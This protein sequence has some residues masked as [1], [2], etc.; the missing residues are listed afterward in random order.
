MGERTSGEEEA[1]LE[2][3]RVPLEEEKVAD[4]DLTANP[5][6]PI[7]GFRI[8][9]NIPLFHKLKMGVMPVM[10]VSVVV[11]LVL[12]V[13]VSCGDTYEYPGVL[14]CGPKI[15]A[16][17]VGASFRDARTSAFSPPSLPQDVRSLR[18]GDAGQPEG[19]TDVMCAVY[20][21]DGRWNN[22]AAGGSVVVFNTSSVV[23][24]YV[25]LF[26]GAQGVP[27]FLDEYADLVWVYYE[28]ALV[29]VV[30]RVDSSYSVVLHTHPYASAPQIIWLELDP[31]YPFNLHQT[32]A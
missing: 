23:V 17:E 8:D 6:S 27:T 7:I 5:V 3:E 1:A 15:S 25:S 2:G 10:R 13:G 14:L 4:A 22:A 29:N 26:D 20:N 24:E 9:A 18:V 19:A 16:E 28:H 21:A 12:V 11:G 32:S 31:L 30:G